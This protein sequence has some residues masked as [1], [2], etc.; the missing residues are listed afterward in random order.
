MA[1]VGPPRGSFLG[2]AIKSQKGGRQQ[3]CPLVE[4]ASQTHRRCVTADRLGRKIASPLEKVYV[5]PLQEVFSGS[6]VVGTKIQHML[7]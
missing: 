4:P 2:G 5:R 6:D 7:R 1:L 3:R